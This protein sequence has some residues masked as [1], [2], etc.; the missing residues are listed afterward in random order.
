[1]SATK[2]FH[3]SLNP[4]DCFPNHLVNILW[5]LHGSYL[6]ILSPSHSPATNTPETHHSFLQTPTPSKTLHLGTF[7][8]LVIARYI[9]YLYKSLP[10]CLRTWKVIMRRTS[11]P[12]NSLTYSSRLSS[13]I[14]P[15]RDFLDSHG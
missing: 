8:S 11:L 3:T 13:I 6:S 12:K 9:K 2:L 4:T 15:L 10:H 5:T 1:M 14:L 7:C